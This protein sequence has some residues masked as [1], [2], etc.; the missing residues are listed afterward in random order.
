M[1]EVAGGGGLLAR[2]L[3]REGAAATVLLVDPRA[4]RAASAPGLRLDAR[5]FAAEYEPPAGPVDLLLAL[6]PDEA[7]DAAFDWATRRGVA[8]AVVPCCVFADRFPRD[9]LV[10][11]YEQL[12]AYLTARYATQVAFL[13]LQGRNV[14]LFGIKGP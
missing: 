5:P 4:E 9:G 2:A 10:R 3:L 13:P 7:T 1:L 12:L 8:F 6:H 14:V 11:T